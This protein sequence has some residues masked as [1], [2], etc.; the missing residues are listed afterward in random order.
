[1]FEGTKLPDPYEDA[2]LI[3]G[4]FY[5]RPVLHMHPNTY[6]ELKKALPNTK[7]ISTKERL[8]GCL[9]QVSE[10]VPEFCKEVLYRL[11]SGKLVKKDEVYVR[12]KFIDYGPEDLDWLLFSKT[13]VLEK[14]RAYYTI[15]AYGIDQIFP[16]RNLINV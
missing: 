14:Q 9:V 5:R 8:G 11:P 10:I 4:K 1:M 15:N 12:S 16:L 7:E 13:V 2:K 6:E 3:L